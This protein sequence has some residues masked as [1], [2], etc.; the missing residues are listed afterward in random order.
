VLSCGSN[1]FGQLGTGDKSNY[2]TPTLIE[3][4]TG[5]RELSAWNYSAAI[6][7]DN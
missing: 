7:E 5:V 4:L 6:T 2:F 3:N 1:N